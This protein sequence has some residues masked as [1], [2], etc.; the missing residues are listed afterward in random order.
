MIAAKT[1]KPPYLSLE[2]FQ[3]KFNEVSDG[4]KY[5][6]NDGVVEK[7]AGMRQS[8]FVLQRKL[9]RLFAT[10]KM[11]AN[12]D[13]FITE[14]NMRTTAFQLRK[15]DFA[16]YSAKHQ[17]AFSKDDDITAQWVCEV[18]SPSD[19]ANHINKKLQEYFAAGVQCVWHVFPELQQV[20]VFTAINKVKICL[21]KDMCS[22][23]PVS[24]EFS[25]TAEDLFVDFDN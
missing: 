10:T 25:I 4:F 22:A 5:E 19:N 18:I 24:E 2:N 16:I 11:F 9:F 7:T 8:H 17:A 6:W 13:F 1:P 21:G 14:G 12:N 15:P 23:A 20:Y 3:K